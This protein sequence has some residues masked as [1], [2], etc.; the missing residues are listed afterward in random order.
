MV[1]RLGG[2][3]DPNGIDA[4]EFRVHK[5]ILSQQSLAFAAMFEHD[6]LEEGQKNVVNITDVKADVFEV[7]FGYIYSGETEG[8]EKFPMELLEVSDKVTHQ[9]ECFV[10]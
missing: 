3:G 4:K 9:L 7:L 8:I 5:N 2:D 6:Q 1:I 10:I